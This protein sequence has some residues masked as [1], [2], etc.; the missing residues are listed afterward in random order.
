MKQKNEHYNHEV[1]PKQF[2]NFPKQSE[3]A[4]RKARQN[5]TPV[6]A[7]IKTPKPTYKALM[8]DKKKKKGDGE[9]ANKR[10]RRENEKRGKGSR[11][12]RR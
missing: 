5:T 10:G 7:T 6:I 2:E 9:K 8:T 4:R 11:L 3:T 1:T 12:N